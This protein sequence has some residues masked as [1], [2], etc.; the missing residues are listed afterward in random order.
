ME[1][2]GLQWP[3]VERRVER[4][5][6]GDGDRAP[7]VE[8]VLVTV[9]RNQDERREREMTFFFFNF[10]GGFWQIWLGRILEVRGSRKDVPARRRLMAGGGMQRGVLVGPAGAPAYES[11]SYVAYM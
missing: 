8:K 2:P 3:R 7:G 6:W 1:N 9:T 11:G 10:L 5:G 4:E